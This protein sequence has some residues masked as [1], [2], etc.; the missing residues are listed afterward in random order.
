MTPASVGIP[1]ASATAVTVALASP[2]INFSDYER[3]I[4]A[5]NKFAHAL[6]SLEEHFRPDSV[7]CRDEEKQR[8][9]DYLERSLESSGSSET[10]CTCEATETFRACRASGRRCA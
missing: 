2:E 6:N 3:H 1:T 9:E 5:A 10:L 7:L 8:I 4:E